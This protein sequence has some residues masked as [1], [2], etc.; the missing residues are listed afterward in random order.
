MNA[1]HEGF[2][3]MFISKQRH[4]NAVRSLAAEVTAKDSR[5]ASLA[6]EVSELRRERHQLVE[7][8]G[9]AIMSGGDHVSRSE[10][11]RGDHL[12]ELG[13]SLPYLL[14]GRRN[15]YGPDDSHLAER[16]LDCIQQLYTKYDLRL[17]DDPVARVHSMFCL[18]MSIFNSAHSIPVE[19]FANDRT[20]IVANVVGCEDVVYEGQWHAITFQPDLSSPQSFV[21][22]VGLTSEGRLTHF[23]V[24]HDL[25][26][27]KCIYESRFEGC[28]WDW[29][30]MRLE[31]ELYQAVSD[32][33]EAFSSSS[34][35]IHFSGGHFIADDNA[36]SALNRT[37]ERVVPLLCR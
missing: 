20:S 22:G 2:V 25:S 21:I 30:L 23:R 35:Q 10:A 4:E 6:Q 33:C 15:W 1:S 29:L 19:R 36:N 7:W 3:N 24:T 9:Y 13:R 27:L 26:K 12:R 16:R 5:I 17:P 31:K 37:F 28:E 14:S 8:A 32:R 11:E 34:P 18:A